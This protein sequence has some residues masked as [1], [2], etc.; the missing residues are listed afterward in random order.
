[1]VIIR[2]LLLFFS[3]LTV[4]VVCSLFWKKSYDLIFVV[5]NKAGHFESSFSWGG[6]AGEGAGVTF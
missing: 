5:T 6:V 3:T 4:D 1:M 2:K